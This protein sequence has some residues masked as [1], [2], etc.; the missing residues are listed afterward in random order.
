MNWDE[1]RGQLAV[2]FVDDQQRAYRAGHA[3]TA[4]QHGLEMLST[5]GVH[6]HLAD[7]TGEAPYWP[8]TFYSEAEPT[9]RVITCQADLDDLGVAWYDHPNKV[10]QAR[11]L[12]FQFQRGGVFARTLPA[13]VLQQVADNEPLPSVHDEAT[14]LGESPMTIARRRA[15]LPEEDIE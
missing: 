12:R 15:G 8:R 5:M 3:L 13:V 7:G 14:R 10:E 2:R 6:F 1:L 11:G 4:I 9:G